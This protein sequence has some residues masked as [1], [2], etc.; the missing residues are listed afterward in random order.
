MYEIVAR[1]IIL[2]QLPLSIPCDTDYPVTVQISCQDIEIGSTQPQSGFIPLVRFEVASGAEWSQRA[3]PGQDGEPGNPG[4]AGG[5]LRLAVAGNWV[6]Q[7][8]ADR[9]SG[10]SIQYRGGNGSNGQSGSQTYRDN[11]FNDSDVE[12]VRG[13]AARGGDAG[14][15]GTI[16]DSEVLALTNHWPLGWKFSIDTGKPG[17]DNEFGKRGQAGKGEYRNLKMRAGGVNAVADKI[18]PGGM[19]CD[20][21]M[22]T[23]WMAKA[24]LQQ[25]TT[26]DEILRQIG[27]MDWRY[28]SPSSIALVV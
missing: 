19:E 4:Y 3:D 11:D 26:K 16:A 10:I 23:F 13:K 22:G 24:D 15:P 14:V 9:V 21:S 25:I 2:D 18:G 27:A 7:G 1:K 28:A 20:R 5:R 12:W 8:A 6:F 17:T